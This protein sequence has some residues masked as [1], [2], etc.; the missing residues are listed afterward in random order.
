MKTTNFI[1]LALIEDQTSL[2]RIAQNSADT[3]NEKKY[4]SYKGIFNSIQDV[5][6]RLIILEGW[7]GSGKTTLMNKIRCDWVKGIILKFELLIFVRLRRLNREFD[8]TLASILRVACPN[9]PQGNANELV[10]YIE[11]KQGEGIVFAFDGLDEYIPQGEDK[12]NECVYKLL[13]G[14]SLTKA[15]VVVTSRPDACVEFHQYA[16]KQIKVVGFFKP[17]VLEYIDHYFDHDKSKGYH[18]TAHLEQY[19]CL[20]NMAYLPLHCAML[21]FLCEEGRVLPETQTEFYKH[22]TI[23]ILSRSICKRQ[24]E[25]KTIFALDQLPHDDKVL[26]DEICRLAFNAM[27]NSK[28]FLT[29]TD[30]KNML[31]DAARPYN[32]MG[33]LGLVVIDHYTMRNGVDETYTFQP[34]TL[35]EYLSAIHIAKLSTS[36]QTEIIKA[37][38]DKRHLSVWRFLCGIMDFESDCTMDIFRSLIAT[39]EDKLF[40]V[41]CCHESQHQSPCK[42]VIRALD[43]QVNFNSNNLSVSDCI[44]IG[45]VISK[46]DHQ[47]IDLTLDKCNINSEGAIALLQEVGEHPFS[48]TLKLAAPRMSMYKSCRL[49]YNLSICRSN[50]EAT[51]FM[52][53]LKLCPAPGL[54]TL[55]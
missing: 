36:E 4:T 34:Q 53:G 12:E 37:C 19:P 6:Q 41:Q 50:T 55:K 42:H 14:G 9:L 48:L 38:H 7:Q 43:G 45:Y 44:A 32:E 27:L 39:N 54:H 51:A 40:Q 20:L 5:D 47:S 3:L 15:L 11:K 30:V 49:F 23:S 25:I 13:C 31:H 52:E 28:Q 2:H 22:Y 17:Q 18:L 16:A 21:A 24:G 46:A 8:R 1:N 35:Q 33:H 29:S 10:S 26:F